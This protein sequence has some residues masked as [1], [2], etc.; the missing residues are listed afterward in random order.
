MTIKRWLSAGEDVNHKLL[1]LSAYLGH[2][3]PSDTYWYLTGT[4]ELFALA[5]DRLEEHVTPSILGDNH[6][7]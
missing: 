4:P 1:L 3:K 7:E 5:S 2:V 6:E